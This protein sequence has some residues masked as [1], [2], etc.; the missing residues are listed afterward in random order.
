ML[1]FNR[2]Y[3]LLTLLL[4]VTEVCIALF[5]HDNFVRPYIGDVLVV[6]LIYCFVKSFLKVSVTKAAIAVLLFAFTV[7]TLQYLAIVEKLGLENNKI[8]KIVIGTSFS[9]EDILAY[10]I[11]IVMVMVSERFISKQQTL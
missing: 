11:G 9:W 7:E 5:V 3:F 8:A 6:I 2:T 4:F 10:I 1:L